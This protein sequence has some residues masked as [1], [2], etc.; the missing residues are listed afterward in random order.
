MASTSN[1]LLNISSDAA[2]KQFDE[3]NRRGLGHASSSPIDR[4]NSQVINQTDWVIKEQPEKF[5]S[6][7]I[8]AHI[9]MKLRD[10]GNSLIERTRVLN[11]RYIGRS[12]KE[13][14]TELIAD[15]DLLEIRQ[16]L[17]VWGEELCKALLYKYRRQGVANP[18][19]L[20]LKLYDTVISNLDQKIAHGS[21]HLYA[22]AWSSVCDC[23]PY[24]LLDS[25]F[26]KAG[27]VHF[28][29]HNRENQPPLIT[30]N[31]PKNIENENALLWH[32]NLYGMESTHFI[33]ELVLN[34]LAS[35]V[36]GSKEIPSSVELTQQVN[37]M[38]GDFLEA[39]PYML[40]TRRAERLI[41]RFPGQAYCA[42]FIFLTEYGL[43]R[44]VIADNEEKLLEG[45]Q[46]SFYRGSIDVDFFGQFS[47]TMHPWRTVDRIYGEEL[48]LKIRYWLLKQ[49][50][51][52]VVE[53]YLKIKNYYLHPEIAKS[54][55]EDYEL[56]A[57]DS[58]SQN[59]WMDEPMPAAPVLPAED[60]PSD[61]QSTGLIPQ[62]RRSRFF[63]LLGECGVRVEQGKGSELK[64]LKDNA[65]PFRLGNHYGPNPTVPRFLI[66]S[67][68]K[69]MEIS[70]D[71]WQAALLANK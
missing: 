65:H 49:I 70:Q 9:S 22:M 43:G 56:Q 36:N 16:E 47:T 55:L 31:T 29:F 2:R 63:K 69:R 45:L 60:V 38:L 4:Y 34:P 41:F 50:H 57:V 58:M 12:F 35:H 17:F 20:Y 62:M 5:L 24:L 33:T 23:I 26:F 64:L 25:L 61:E 15:L 37:L 6:S 42:T 1:V 48:G 30:L 53:S 8:T 13:I 7:V 54:A 32:T 19:D 11:N 21:D 71:E 44:F 14:S 10:E 59:S 67:I 28:Q 51:S 68:L 40:S 27:V 52:R 46:K 18:L 66:E 39:L 3:Y